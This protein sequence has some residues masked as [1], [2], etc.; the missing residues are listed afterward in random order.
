MPF[1]RVMSV[2]R[3][4]ALAVIWSYQARRRRARSRGRVWRKVW[5]AVWA[6]VMAVRVSAAVRSGMVAMG[7][8]VAGSLT[9]KVVKEGEVMNWP[10]MKAASF[11]REGSLS[12]GAS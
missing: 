12:C 9:V 8:F 5:R 7:V 1:S 2:A 3:S 11:R 6:A 4:S 10:L